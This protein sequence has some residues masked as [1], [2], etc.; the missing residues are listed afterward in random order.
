MFF[1]DSRYIN[2]SPYQ[3]TLADGTILQAAR[4]PLPGPTA[5]LG[6][7][8]RVQGERLDNLAARYLADA[9][10]FWRLCDTNDAMVPDALAVR[11]L[12]GIPINAPVGA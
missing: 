7:H 6:Y 9:T 3:V 4:T 1:S 10:T 8:R 12:I 2:L 5:V 11:V